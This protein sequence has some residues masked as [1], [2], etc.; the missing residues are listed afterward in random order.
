[1][2]TDFLFKNFVSSKEKLF[3]VNNANHKS[4]NQLKGLQK[5]APIDY[6]FEATEKSP[7]RLA[8]L[9]PF[10][11]ADNIIRHLNNLHTRH[12]AKSNEMF[13]PNYGGFY[14]TYKRAL[15]IP[16][17]NDSQL[18]RTYDE[19]N[20]LHVQTK[21]FVEYIKSQIDYFQTQTPDFNILVIYSP[22]SFTKF[23]EDSNYDPDFNLHDA[24]KLYGTNTG[25]KIQ[26]IEERSLD[27]YDK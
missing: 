18:F 8:V 7:I 1:M 12:A 23:R 4:I 14:E 21:T 2:P 25:V 17:Q 3:D 24:I 15:N 5:Y 6:S 9:T 26:F 13:L 11:Q 19:S 20:M 16:S 10:Q 22:K 27:A